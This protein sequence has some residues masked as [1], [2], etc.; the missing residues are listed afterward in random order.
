MNKKSVKYVGKFLCVSI[1]FI[2]LI[3]SAQRTEAKERKI[4]QDTVYDLKNGIY[5]VS[6]KVKNESHDTGYFTFQMNDFRATRP[7]K[8]SAGKS[9][10]IES[11]VAITDGQLYVT[12]PEQDGMKVE[13]ILLG[14][15]TENMKK[16]KDTLYFF[17][18]STTRYYQWK[19]RGGMGEGF[20]QTLRGYKEC[21]I[22]TV[23]VR[24]KDIVL[25]SFPD[26]DVY[27][28]SRFGQSTLSMMESG[29]FNELLC[30]ISKGD[31][32]IISLGH[33]DFMRRA[34][35]VGTTPEEYE[36]NLKEM[37]SKLRQYGAVPIL[38]SPTAMCVFENGRIQNK[39]LECETIMEKVAKEKEC[40]Y[41][42]LG[43]T[44]REY[45]E[46]IGEER[47]KDLF[48]A[49][50]N[51]H[52]N[53][54]GAVV[55]GKMLAGLIS[56]D[57]SLKAISKHIESDETGAIEAIKKFAGIFT[58]IKKSPGL[59]LELLAVAGV[60]TIGGG[61]AFIPQLILA[62]IGIVADAY[63]VCCTGKQ[64]I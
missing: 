10:I 58:G 32:V 42:P 14:E 18:D 38:C 63:I 60:I 13:K 30:S 21:K 24:F 41:L 29:T 43:K 6:V 39:L 44:H 52:L 9:R 49:G 34:R 23:K 1:V 26:Y 50:D 53:K 61:N 64:K 15:R 46:L 3:F 4:E 48:I 54:K 40:P 36:N 57:E 37:I 27:N 20:L 5:K 28:F 45:L 19:Q 11:R 17:G 59:R 8:I 22:S 33:N 31:R 62:G 51:T 25:A 2:Y 12:I 16:E 47:A 7:K 56:E 55:T 35:G